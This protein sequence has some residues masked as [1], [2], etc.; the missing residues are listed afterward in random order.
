MHSANMTHFSI[1]FSDLFG[2]EGD[3]LV[4]VADIIELFKDQWLNIS[5]L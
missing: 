3:I 2:Y 5:I 4:H 1:I